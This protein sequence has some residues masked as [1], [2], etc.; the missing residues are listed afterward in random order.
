MLKQNCV[1]GKPEEYLEH[2]QIDRWRLTL[3]MALHESTFGLGS[4]PRGVFIQIPEYN[5][6]SPR[7]A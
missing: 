4:V 1:L 5:F 6:V 7:L 2:C 3:W